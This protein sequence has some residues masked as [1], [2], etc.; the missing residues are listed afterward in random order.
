MGDL[1]RDGSVA[2]RRYLTMDDLIL[3]ICPKNRL[4]VPQ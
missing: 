4:C 3:Y 2:W 1:Y